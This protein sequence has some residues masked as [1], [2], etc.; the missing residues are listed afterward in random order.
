MQWMVYCR[1]CKM[2]GD[3]MNKNKVLIIIA[4]II[5]ITAIILLLNGTISA[6]S[7]NSKKNTK[8]PQK[9]IESISN[10]NDANSKY[11]TI[12]SNN[13]RQNSSDKIKEKRIDTNIVVSD[14][15]IKSNSND[16][17]NA[18]INLSITNNGVDILDKTLFVT[19]ID[20]NNDEYTIIFPVKELKTGT[21][22][23]LNEKTNVKVI[24]AVDYRIKIGE[25]TPQG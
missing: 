18:N 11:Y 5:L 23:E 2:V 14:M 17:E 12:D 20:S 19:F 16:L 15:T 3:K 25:F 21:T 9:Q 24:D 13:N 22:I 4:G 1:I 8:E 7:R 6:V 10:K